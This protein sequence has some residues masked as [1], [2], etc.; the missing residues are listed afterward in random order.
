MKNIRDYL[1]KAFRNPSNLQIFSFTFSIMLI[2]SITIGPLIYERG[3]SGIEEIL[4]KK[5]AREFGGDID[6][7]VWVYSWI[8][9]GTNNM[10]NATGPSQWRAIQWDNSC[11]SRRITKWNREYQEAIQEA[12]GQ[13]SIIQKKYDS[14][15]LSVFDCNITYQA[16]N[17]LGLILDNLRA[18][19]SNANYVKPYRSDEENSIE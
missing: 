8:K 14:D 12:C 13:I 16:K 9:T 11:F 4:R 18:V 6:V 19:F 10:I 17:D 15:C 1:I 2:F 7:E 3:Q 5:N